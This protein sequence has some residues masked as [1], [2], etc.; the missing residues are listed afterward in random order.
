MCVHVNWSPRNLETM[1]KKEKKGFH[2]TSKQYLLRQAFAQ[3]WVTKCFTETIEL[4]F[5]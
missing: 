5:L 1:K 2:Q 4:S 3:D